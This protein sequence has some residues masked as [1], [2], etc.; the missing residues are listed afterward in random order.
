MPS[1]KKTRRVCYSCG[2]IFPCTVCGGTGDDSPF[3]SPFPSGL[4]DCPFCEGEWGE[5]VEVCELWDFV[6]AECV[7]Q[8][9]VIGAKACD[10]RRCNKGILL[11]IDASVLCPKC[12]KE[13]EAKLAA[14]QVEPGQQTIFIVFDG[15]PG[16]ESGHFIEVEN[17]EGQSIN[18]GKWLERPDGYWALAI[19]IEGSPK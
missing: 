16:N 12:K 4:A 14:Q 6:E 7:D 13:A 19:Q 10:G 18:V 2:C 17:A 11:G 1:P 9:A 3:L 15:P 5:G 8:Y